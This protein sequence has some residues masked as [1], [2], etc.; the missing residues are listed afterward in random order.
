MFSRIHDKLGTAGLIIAVVALIAAFSGAALAKGVI[1]T[2]L[3]QISPKVQKKLKGAMGPQGPAGAQGPKGD[4][5]P[6]GDAGAHGPEGPEGP[7]GVQ[8]NPGPTETK[9]PAGKTMKGLWDFQA[10]QNAFGLGIMSIT[11]PL[12]VEPAPTFEWVPSTTQAGENEHCPG[13][14]EIPKAEPGWFC[15]Y[16]DVIL[17]TTGPPSER[18]TGS[19]SIGF[20]GEWTIEDETALAMGTWAV[21]AAE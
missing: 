15:M 6:K 16:A 7:Q 13:D 14:K 8:G 3:S 18:A 1:I 9:L 20:R 11:F 4:P 2:K 17:G 12:R 10:N 5:G 19:P 21:T